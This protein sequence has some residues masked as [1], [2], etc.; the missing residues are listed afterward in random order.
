MYNNIKCAEFVLFCCFR[1]CV[2]NPRIIKRATERR[3]RPGESFC[4]DNGA[5]WFF[6]G[7]G[8]A[9]RF[10]GG[11]R[12]RSGCRLDGLPRYRRRI[13]TRSA[14]SDF[15]YPSRSRIHTH[16]RLKMY[17]MSPLEGCAAA[18]A[19]LNDSGWASAKALRRRRRRRRHRSRT[20]LR[21]LL[22]ANSLYN[23]IIHKTHGYSYMIAAVAWSS[24]RR[25]GSSFL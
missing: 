13:P 11:M 22:A 1:S 9:Q 12:G 10:R 19:G 14:V 18:L 6:N 15:P 20:N 24:A 8:R 17:T 21:S 25:A 16:T 2:Q 4:R 23:I 5:H 3:R 7:A